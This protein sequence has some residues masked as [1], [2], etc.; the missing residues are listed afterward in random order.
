MTNL[1]VLQR[2]FFA[3]QRKSDGAFM[4]QGRGRGFTADE[5]SISR[6]PRLFTTHHAA[7]VALTWWRKG[8]TYVVRGGP[9]IFGDG[10]DE[11]FRVE[12]RSG[13]AEADLVVVPILISVAHEIPEAGEARTET[14]TAYP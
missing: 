7:E 14:A 5:P 13:R 9:D 4:P 8:V 12:K 6:P 11:D 2:R 1:R 3:I 10:Y